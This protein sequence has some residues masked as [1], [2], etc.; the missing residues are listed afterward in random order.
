LL[1][2]ASPVVTN[3]LRWE[4][5]VNWSKNVSEVLDLGGPSQIA[6]GGIGGN[7]LIARVG[8]PVFE[9][10]GNVPV[11]DAQGRTVVNAAGQ[12]LINPNKQVIGNTQY[13]FVGGITNKLS[14]KGVSLSGTLDIRNGGVL[15]SRTANIGYFSGTAPVT[16][17]NDR[18][19]FIVPNSGLQVVDAN[20]D[21][22][23][24]ENGFPTTVENTTALHNTDGQIQGYWQN[25]GARLDKSFLVSKSYVKLRELVL[26][27]S[28]PKALLQRTPFGN[29]DISLIG[30]NLFL[31]VPK[32]NV[33]ID[34]EQT[35]FGNDIG[36]EWG[37]FGA[38]PTTRSYGFNI[39]IT[40]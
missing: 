2:T 26:A 15:Y 32:E 22:V 38:S 18:N 23:L 9:I 19:P 10:E 17:Y 27:Y 35:T 33:F 6:L 34:P 36:S 20:G 29:I 8:G 30:R 28:I 16:T 31:W 11:R 14:F 25:G 39:R 7:S 21:A 12:P 5:S 24:D 3:S 40:L 1:L 13:K 37:E 4:V